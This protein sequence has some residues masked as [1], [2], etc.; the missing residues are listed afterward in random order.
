MNF[1]EMK[2]AVQRAA[3]RELELRIS[4]PINDPQIVGNPCDVHVEGRYLGWTSQGNC[5]E[6]KKIYASTPSLIRNKTPKPIDSSD[7]ATELGLV[8]KKCREIEADLSIG[9]VEGAMVGISDLR[10]KIDML[11]ARA[12]LVN[13]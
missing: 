6:L 8:A 2:K 9:T 4:K 10:S 12:L 13:S 1:E 11:H 5:E 3:Q 7:I